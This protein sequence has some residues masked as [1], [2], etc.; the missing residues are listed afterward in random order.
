MQVIEENNITCMT[1]TTRE[2]E[3]E[4][5]HKVAHGC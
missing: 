1:H 3:I 2:D 4:E 5:I